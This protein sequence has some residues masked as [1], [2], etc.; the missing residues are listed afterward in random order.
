MN[1]NKIDTG[2][3]YFFMII[4][5]STETSWNGLNQNAKCVR[6]NSSRPT[7]TKCYYCLLNS[8]LI[9][10]LLS[11]VTGNDYF[12]TIIVFSTETS[13]KGLNQ[14]TKCILEKHLDLHLQNVITV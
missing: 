1:Y 4:V 14:N 3:Y 6:E 11:L 9:V 10:T 8:P 13:W 12:F 7:P 5:C 2:N